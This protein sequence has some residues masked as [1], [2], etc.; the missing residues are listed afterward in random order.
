MPR[1]DA[2]AHVFHRGLMVAPG[3]R[4]RP[5]YD[6]PLDAYLAV[7]DAHDVACGVLVQPSFLGTDNTY[8]LACLAEARGRLRGVVVVDPDI[9]LKSLEVLDVGGVVGVRFN[10]IGRSTAEIQ[11]PMTEELLRRVAS[12]GWHVEVHAEGLQLV[13][14]LAAL[15]SFCGAIVV[16]HLGRP[17]PR[18]GVNCPGFQALL[19]RSDDERLHV[20]LSAPYRLGSLD[21]RD[22]TQRLVQ[23]LGPDR[24]VWGSDWPWTQHEAG[25][26]YDLLAPSF[27]GLDAG[28]AAALDATALRLFGFTASGGHLFTG[29]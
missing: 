4:Y 22:A 21:L 26:G 15:E 1:V 18:R 6:A 8:L 2:H 19:E 11:T 24:L 20:K 17:D 3:A 27:F 7:L 5:D 23:A 25:Q 28:T 12:L 14:A 16:D 13:A 9:S 10:L 29:S